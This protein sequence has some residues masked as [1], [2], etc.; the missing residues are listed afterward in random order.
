V[1][2]AALS[3]LDT[4][5]ETLRALSVPR[6]HGSPAATVVAAHV[7]KDLERSD[8]RVTEQIFTFSA[9]PGRYG[10]LIIGVVLMVALPVTGFLAHTGLRVP[11]LA[12][13]LVPAAFIAGVSAFSDAA[14]LRLPFARTQGVNLIA[15]PTGDAPRFLVVAH[16]DSKSQPLPLMLRVAGVAVAVLSWIILM[17]A[18]GAGAV[19]GVVTPVTGVVGG[20]AGLLVACCGVGNRSEGALD[21]ASGVAALLRIAATEAELGSSDVAFLVTDAEELFLAGARAASTS[22]SDVEV[23]INLDGLDD[24]GPIV[25]I[26]GRSPWRANTTRVSWTIDQCAA[27]CDTSVRRRGLPPGLLLDHLPFAHPGRQAITIMRG[28]VFSMARV[29]RPSDTANRI[30]GRG[31]ALVARVVSDTLA[32]LR[33]DPGVESSR[34]GASNVS[35]SRRLPAEERVARRP[36]AG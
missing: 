24:R 13:L 15:G 23:V 20:L 3:G 35:A 7:R 25:L 36:V 5:L 17:V 30:S 18:L 34:S 9:A 14:V 19:T 8:W 12:V 28:N 31:V 29:H 4:I 10:A 1:P 16:R 27:A 32:R 2:T 21:N 33:A 6:L 11:A 22:F 26:E